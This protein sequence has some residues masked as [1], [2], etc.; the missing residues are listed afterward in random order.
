M[1]NLDAPPSHGVKLNTP[2]LS[3]MPKSCGLA[4]MTSPTLSSHRVPG[5]ELI[6][7]RGHVTLDARSRYDNTKPR[8]LSVRVCRLLP[9]LPR[10][11]WNGFLSAKLL[12]TPPI[13]RTWKIDGC[14]HFPIPSSSGTLS[15][16]LLPY[17]CLCLISLP[18]GVFFFFLFFYLPFGANLE[19]LECAL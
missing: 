7:K 2:Q 1:N 18:W 16:R 15:T 9:A 5:R 13:I 12:I 3:A 11:Q 10:R 6:A 4:G 19:P 14:A 8:H 17:R